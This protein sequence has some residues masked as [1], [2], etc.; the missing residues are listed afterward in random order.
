MILMNRKRLLVLPILLIILPISGSSSL[1]DAPRTKCNIRI[2]DPHI[3]KSILRRY[4]Y[5]AVKI[6]ARSK[7]NVP[8]TNLRLTVTIF[9]TGFLR[10][11]EV[12]T[13]T[14]SKN[15]LIPADVIIKNSDTWQK[16]ITSRPT[17]YFGAATATALINGKLVRTPKAVTEK[18]VVLPCGT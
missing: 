5:D 3:S 7:C 18:S 17:R 4:G 13:F 6:N 2:D 9:K 8:M 12:R 10:N 14:F 1:A 16:C 15:E 11:H